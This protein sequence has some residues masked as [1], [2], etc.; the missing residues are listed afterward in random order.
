MQGPR[1][2]VFTAE[3][4]GSTPASSL[5]GPVT[6]RKPLSPLSVSLHWDAVWY[7]L[8]LLLWWLV[9]WIGLDVPSGVSSD[10]LGSRCALV[11]WW[12]RVLATD[13]GSVEFRQ[14]LGAREGNIAAAGGSGE[15]GGWGS[16]LLGQGK[17]GQPVRGLRAEPYSLLGGGKGCLPAARALTLLKP[18]IEVWTKLRYAR[19]RPGPWGHSSEVISLL[20]EL[21]L[22]TP[23]GDFPF[24]LSLNS[25]RS[26]CGVLWREEG[27][28]RGEGR[29]GKAF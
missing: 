22:E 7:V 15:Q 17:A 5:L 28:L 23:N 14:V 3:E 13:G 16:R 8:L 20:R 11:C 18:F 19:H 4:P 25:D 24:F 9:P 10:Q 26:A 2:S 29:A 6:S 1:D 12:P 27:A 21:G